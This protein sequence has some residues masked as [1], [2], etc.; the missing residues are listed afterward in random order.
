MDRV[1]TQQRKEGL[2]SRRLKGRVLRTQGRTHQPR[3][4]DFVHLSKDMKSQVVTVHCLVAYSFLGPR[5]EGFEIDHVN[6]DPSDNR[7]C[8]LEYVTREE[9]LRRAKAMGRLGAKVDSV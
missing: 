8:N 6:G 2:V 9:N 3:G 5:P 1:Q 4:R 7:A